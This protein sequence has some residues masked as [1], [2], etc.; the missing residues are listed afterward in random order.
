[1][2]VS[3]V[4]IVIPARYGSSRLPGKALLEIN[5]K[6]LIQRV[7]EQCQL[8]LNEAFVCV[9]TDDE[10]IHS[11]IKSLGGH[12]FM[13]SNAHLSGTDRCAEI[14]EKFLEYEFVINVQGDEPFIDPDEIK[15]LIQAMKSGQG[16]I[17][18]LIQSINSSKRLRTKVW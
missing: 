14:A 6:S 18:T 17:Y 9:A 2:N 8:L 16:K 3:N 5:G 12:V 10:R 15:Q 4:I 7:Y 1:M 13:T 11:H